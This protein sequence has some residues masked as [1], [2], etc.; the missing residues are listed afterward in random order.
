MAKKKSNKKDDKKKG[1]K[2]K[3]GKKKESK[4][5]I[6]KLKLKLRKKKD[7]K[8]KDSKK[9]DAKKEID[10]LRAAGASDASLKKYYHKWRTFQMS[11]HL[12][13]WVELEIDFSNEYLEYLS[14]YQ[15]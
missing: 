3:D 12:P 1:G 5:S 11:D 2:K 15:A 13:L 9:K 7:R 8:K 6:L 10:G 4:K 14:T